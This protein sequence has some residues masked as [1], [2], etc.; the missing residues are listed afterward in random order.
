MK[1]KSIGL[2][3]GLYI[4]EESINGFEYEVINAVANLDNVLFWHRNPSRTDSASTVI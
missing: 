1:T 4:E 2:A 3:K